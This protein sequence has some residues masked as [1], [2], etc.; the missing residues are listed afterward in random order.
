MLC[1]SP[2][3]QASQQQEAFAAAFR[4]MWTIEGNTQVLIPVR[5]LAVWIETNVLLQLSSAPFDK[6]DGK[7]VPEAGSCANC[8]KRCDLT[9]SRKQL[10]DAFQLA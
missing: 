1:S 10:S 7:L 2:R 6:Q 3:L 9:A 4:G 5:E 8:P